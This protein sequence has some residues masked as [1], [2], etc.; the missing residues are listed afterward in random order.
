[1]LFYSLLALAANAPETNVEKP[2][3]RR[4]TIKTNVDVKDVK[5]QVASGWTNTLWLPISATAPN[6]A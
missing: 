3:A 1:M 4:V 2:G 5:W 6:R